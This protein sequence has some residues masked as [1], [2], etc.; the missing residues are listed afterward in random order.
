MPRPQLRRCGI[1]S[2][3]YNHGRANSDTAVKILD[4]LVGE[5][6]AARGHEAPDGRW[7]IG[8][9]NPIFC[10][11]QIHRTRAER[12]G[13]TAG[14]EARQVRLALDHLLGREPVRPFLHPT[15]VL[16]A[17]PGEALAAD[18]DAVAHCL[19]VTDR[20]IE[21][22]VRRINNDGSRRLD[23]GVIDDRAMKPRR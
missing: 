9:V 23:C 8:A 7:L 4:V 14:H 1:R 15:D 6:N 3:Q 5:T 10:A 22:G 19:T 13:F 16:S 12:I 2:R 20:Q 18:T 11:A 17:R 21:V